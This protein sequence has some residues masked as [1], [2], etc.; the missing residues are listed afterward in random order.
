MA[1]PT[2]ASADIFETLWVT[3]V[4]TEYLF[5]RPGENSKNIWGFF[6]NLFC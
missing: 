5:C 1:S 6:E 2:F 4:E 3:L